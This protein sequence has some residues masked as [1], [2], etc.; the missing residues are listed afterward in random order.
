M[1][2]KIYPGAVFE[3]DSQGTRVAIFKEDFEL[4]LFSFSYRIFRT[5]GSGQRDPIFHLI[6]NS[7][8][9]FAKASFLYISPLPVIAQYLSIYYIL[10]QIYELN[11]RLWKWQNLIKW[12]CRLFSEVFAVCGSAAY[13]I[14]V[15]AWDMKLNIKYSKKVLKCFFLVW[16]KKWFSFFIRWPTTPSPSFL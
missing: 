10:C 15:H 14:L 1:K 16:K 5:Y 4:I 3:N 2:N 9:P 12:L 6:V 13:N 7:P 8:S 11:E